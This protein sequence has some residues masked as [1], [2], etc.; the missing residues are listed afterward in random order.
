VSPQ[1]YMFES[2]SLVIQDSTLFGNRVFAGIIKV[3]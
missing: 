1:K 3:K 2:Q